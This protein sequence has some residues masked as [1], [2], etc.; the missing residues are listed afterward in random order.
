MKTIFIDWKFAFDHIP[1]IICFQCFKIGDLNSLFNSWNSVRTTKKSH[2]VLKYSSLVNGKTT[3]SESNNLAKCVKCF[4]EHTSC[5][6]LK[7]FIF[8]LSN[9]LLD[10]LNYGTFSLNYHVKMTM[11]FQHVK[12]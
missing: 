9:P 3:V 8:P 12:K 10:L 5:C 1:R 7:Y 2:L 6:A 11:L 4:A